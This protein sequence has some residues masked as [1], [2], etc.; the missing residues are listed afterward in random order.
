MGIFLFI[1]SK[2][3]IKT[4]CKNLIFFSQTCTLSQSSL[5][6]WV[7]PTATGFLKKSVFSLALVS[8]YCKQSDR[9]GKIV[10]FINCRKRFRDL[11]NQC[12]TYSMCYYFADKF[13]D[14]W[15][16]SIEQKC[17]SS[18]ISR[19]EI[20]LRNK[21]VFN[22]K[23]FDWWEQYHGFSGRISPQLSLADQVEI[24]INY[25][26]FRFLGW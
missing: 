11:W 7:P 2:T 20:I 19:R 23:Y 10:Y 9:R 17:N 22:F 14:G 21:R 13:K 3:N 5:A 4:K 1:L 15:G 25:S 8:V 26:N 24:C 16:E 6:L 18:I 12:L